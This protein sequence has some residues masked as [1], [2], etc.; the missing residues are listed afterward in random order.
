MDKEIQEMKEKIKISPIIPKELIEQA[1]RQTHNSFFE[2]KNLKKEKKT[3]KFF[4]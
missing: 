1:K 2:I 4:D 3:L